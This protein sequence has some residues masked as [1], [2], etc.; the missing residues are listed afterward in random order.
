[1]NRPLIGIYYYVWY[2]K[3]G[4]HWNDEVSN[5]VIDHPTL[6][7]YDSSDEDII[8]R[9]IEWIE[10]CELDFIAI[11]WWGRKSY[12]DIV[13]RKV[14][15]TLSEKSS[16]RFCLVLERNS[17]FDNEHL[18]SFFNQPNYVRVDGKPLVVTYETSPDNDLNCYFVRYMQNNAWI[19]H[20]L[21]GYDDTHLGRRRSWQ[22]PRLNGE[23]YRLFWRETKLLNPRMA[24]V[25]SFNEWHERSAIE[26][27]EEWGDF[28]LTL[29][30][31]GARSL[32]R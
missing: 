1:M 28:Y 6:A 17:F 25:V 18:K 9:H 21:A 15:K 12:E 19:R 32:S 10:S 13:A 20:L 31:M 27:S 3:E 8:Q 16:L 30:K 26:P 2:S 4:R 22:L 24:F 5:A 7:H 23:T 29:T 11:S 14:I